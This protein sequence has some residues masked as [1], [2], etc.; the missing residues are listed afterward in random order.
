M[1]A[2]GQAWGRAWGAA[3]GA[4][5]GARREVVRLSSPLAR[6]VALRSYIGDGNGA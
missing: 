1:S 3:W 2:W 4:I 5:F 6:T